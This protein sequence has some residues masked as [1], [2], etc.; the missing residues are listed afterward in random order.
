M[1]AMMGGMTANGGK[2]DGSD[3]SVTAMKV[4]MTAM[5]EG[6]ATSSSLAVFC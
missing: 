5:M 4:G 1:T 3:G 2:G 6:L